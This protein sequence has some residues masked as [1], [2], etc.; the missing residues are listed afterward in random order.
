MNNPFRYVYI[1]YFSF[2]GVR[3]QGICPRRNIKLISII[4]YEL[5][6]KRLSL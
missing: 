5:Y 2:H 3:Y 6:V 4:F 1:L